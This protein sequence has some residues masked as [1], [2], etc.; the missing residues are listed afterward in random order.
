MTAGIAGN[1]L[2]TLARRASALPDIATLTGPEDGFVTATRSNGTYYLDP[3]YDGTWTGY[4]SDGF[5][6]EEQGRLAGWAEK[7]D[8]SGARWLLSS[9]DTPFIKRL[10]SGRTITVVESRRSVGKR[11]ARLCPALWLAAGAAPLARRHLPAWVTA[12]LAGR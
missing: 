12:G 5:G 10:Y 9:S 8:L 3:P 6:P 7:L 2:T 1:E 11:P 4:S